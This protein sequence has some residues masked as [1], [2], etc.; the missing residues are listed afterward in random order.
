LPK[1]ARFRF[2]TFQIRL[3]SLCSRMFGKETLDQRPESG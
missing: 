2:G 1:G 3:C